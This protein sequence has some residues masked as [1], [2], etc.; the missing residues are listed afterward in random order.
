ML[1]REREGDPMSVW[2]NAQKWSR[3]WTD[4]RSD[5]DQGS[6]T[7][8]KEPPMKKILFST[9]SLLALSGCGAAP[10]EGG[11]GNS[12]SAPAP[13]PAASAASSGVAGDGAELL[14]TV[15]LS[16]THTVSFYQVNESDGLAVESFHMDKDEPALTGKRLLRTGLYAEV[17][18]RLAGKT[19]DSNAVEKLQAFDTKAVAA[20]AAMAGKDVDTSAL[21]ALEQA[22]TTAPTFDL[23]NGNVEKDF[24]SDADWFR[25]SYCGGCIG[26]S[27]SRP[28]WGAPSTWPTCGSAPDLCDFFG[29]PS[30]TFKRKSKNADIYVFNLAF[31]GDV[32]YVLYLANATENCRWAEI[33][34]QH[35]G[36]GGSRLY[37]GVAAPRWA[38]GVVS[39]SSTSWTRGLDTV[40]PENIGVKIDL[41]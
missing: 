14:A 2:I 32:N 11:E 25:N 30:S 15:S 38:T 33:V 39:T 22:V 36:R 17:Y 4:L 1:P 31:S 7:D 19:I 41:Y 21:P 18:Q 37:D 27:G 10:A 3:G 6:V 5:C 26:D 12:E 23:V 13:A 29:A 16:P 40:Q 9:L 34:W 28:N 35:C 8:R 24:W 20:E